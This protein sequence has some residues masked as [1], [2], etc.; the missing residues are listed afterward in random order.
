MVTFD[1]MIQ[2]QYPYA[3]AG[4][5]Y[6]LKTDETGNPALDYWNEEKLGAMPNIMKLH[7]EYMLMAK[8]KKDLLPKFDDT[9]P[10]P[11]L[12][13]KKETVRRAEQPSFRIPIVNVDLKTGIVT[14]K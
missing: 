3:V 8:K 1:K 9:D 5:D 7:T 13:A 4:S 14:Q 11:W 2:W 6:T 12:N 10:A